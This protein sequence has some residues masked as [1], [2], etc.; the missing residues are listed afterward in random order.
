MFRS[1]QIKED[2]DAIYL[3]SEKIKEKNK[4][5]IKAAIFTK[6]ICCEGDVN[7]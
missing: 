4:R 7:A 6:I 3:P 2:Q 1:V 5:D